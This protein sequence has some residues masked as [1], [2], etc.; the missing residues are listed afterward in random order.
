MQKCGGR[1][2]RPGGWITT[3]GAN[4]PHS[5]PEARLPAQLPDTFLPADQQVDQ[6]AE[7]IREHDDE[8]P[9]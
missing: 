1:Q 5:R 9:D 8:R 4:A 7:P 2:L 6:R 3:L